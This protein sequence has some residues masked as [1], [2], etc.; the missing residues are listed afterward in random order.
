MRRK[1]A[2]LTGAAFVVL[3]LA[4]SVTG[5]SLDANASGAKVIAYYSSHVDRLRVSQVLGGLA[6]VVGVWFFAMLRDFLRQDDAVRGLAATAFGGVILFAASLGLANG[7][8]GAL[9][10][11]P[12]HLAT[13]SAQTLNLMHLD[14]TNGLSSVG[15][16]IL[17]SAFGLAILRSGLL[18]RWLGWFAFPFAI[19]ALVPPITILAGVAT[20]I[21]TLIISILLYQRQSVVASDSV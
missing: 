5:S 8:N 18:P 1:L 12:S 21:W 14:G 3:S 4:A 15:F 20:L 17:L 10:N 11:S 7:A 16:A 6:I 9:A 19:I 13:A 2:P